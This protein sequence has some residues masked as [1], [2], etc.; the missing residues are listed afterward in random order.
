M[1]DAAED[2]ERLSVPELNILCFR[3]LPP[4][5]RRR[6][7]RLDPH[8]TQAIELNER[9]DAIN[10]DIWSEL[11]KTRE[12]L[13]SRTT[14]ESTVHARP[15]VALRAVLFHPA[16][17]REDLQLLVRTVGEIGTRATSVPSCRHGWS[18]MP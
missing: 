14:L 15:V 10:V 13:L 3:F 1:V 4:V 8:S 9:I 7:D 12:N 5:W 18:D 6:L 16:I 17:E 2:L 11:A